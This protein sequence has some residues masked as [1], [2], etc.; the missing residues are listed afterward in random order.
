MLDTMVTAA[1]EPIFIVGAPR[2]G[3][4]LLAA[5]LAAHSELSCGPETHFFRWLSTTDPASLI[6]EQNW[7][8]LAQEFLFS[9]TL[10]NF[11]KGERTP[12]I[13]KYEL[14]K[15]EIQ[16]YLGKQPPSIRAL[17][18]SVTVPFMQRN[19]K[20]R[21]V[22][23]TPDH[24]NQLELIRNYFPQS[25]IIR[26][27]RDPRDVALSMTKV[28][29]GAESILHALVAW[30]QMDLASDPFFEGD[31]N[32]YTLHFED[33]LTSPQTTLHKL[34]EFIGEG[35]EEN[36]L[37]T[38]STGKQLNSANVAW[39]S[40]ASQ[41]IDPSRIGVWRVELEP[42]QKL[43]AEA[44]IG[45]RLRAHGYSL[46]ESFEQV[47]EI[48]PGYSLAPKYAAE[49]EILPFKNVRFWKLRKEE[50]TTVK[51]FL[52]DPSGEKWL[53]EHKAQS[54]IKALQLAIGIGLDR[55]RNNSIYWVRQ[56][57][58]TKWSG[59]AAALLKKLL[60]PYQII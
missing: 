23:K 10:P 5:M 37:N 1:K 27:M 49:L 33:L 60:N 20:K 18:S 40:K 57:T 3:T 45:D 7:P 6:Q 44:L 2:S 17:L 28:P 22:E 59:Y 47:G 51:V 58:Q 31:H 53:A 26:I 42:P 29:W 8:E 38:S 30:K 14:S 54:F 46:D 43:W 13:E 16:A 41:P 52:G 19:R 4:T 25:P 21:W 48:I 11:S 32:T 34:C 9:I 36:M 24:I 39:K 56:D 15:A 55:L 35:Y 12:L 50:L